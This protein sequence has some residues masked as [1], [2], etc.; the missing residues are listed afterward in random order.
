MQ[1]QSSS[2]IIHFLLLF[3]KTDEHEHETRLSPLAFT[4]QS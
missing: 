2:I 1:E 3:Q 4:K